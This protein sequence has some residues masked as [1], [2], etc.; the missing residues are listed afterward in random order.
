[1][2]DGLHTILPFTPWMPFHVKK[3]SLNFRYTTFSYL[4]CRFRI[5]FPRRKWTVH[6]WSVYKIMSKVRYG[7]GWAETGFVWLRRDFVQHRLR[8]HNLNL[9]TPT[10][11]IVSL[12]TTAQI[13]FVRRQISD[14]RSNDPAPEVTARVPVRCLS[15]LSFLKSDFH[16]RRGCSKEMVA[17]CLSLGVQTER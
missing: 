8:Q 17:T 13:P 1:M 15:Y 9:L 3:K 7:L 16:H 5:A 4:G 12:F 6:A 10:T 2:K 11:I 14:C